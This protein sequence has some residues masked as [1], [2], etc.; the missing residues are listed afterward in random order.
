MQGERGE[1]D[2]DT[3]LGLWAVMMNLAGSGTMHL[4]RSLLDRSSLGRFNFLAGSDRNSDCEAG[5]VPERR[6]AC[7]NHV[8]DQYVT[9]Q[10]ADGD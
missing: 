1:G 10:P 2:D 7:F 5:P 9:A 8:H 6:L 4:K 3:S